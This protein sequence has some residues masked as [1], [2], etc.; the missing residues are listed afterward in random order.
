MELKII[1]PRYHYINIINPD[2]DETEEA[3]KTL[4]EL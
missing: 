4:N 3:A 1:M 2:D